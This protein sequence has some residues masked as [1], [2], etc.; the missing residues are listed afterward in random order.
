[1][2]KSDFTIVFPVRFPIGAVYLEM[3]PETVHTSNSLCALYKNGEVVQRNGRYHKI[4]REILHLVVP[5]AQVQKRDGPLSQKKYGLHRFLP[6]AGGF[7]V[8]ETIWLA[9]WNMS[10]R[11]LGAELRAF[12]FY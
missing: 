1:L 10:V 5:L 2:P 6:H 4:R 7:P 8:L 9:A 3:C 12:A 11:H